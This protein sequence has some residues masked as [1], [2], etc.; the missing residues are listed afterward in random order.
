MYGGD[1]MRLWITTSV[2][3]LL[4]FFV[5]RGLDGSLDQH[6]VALSILSAFAISTGVALAQSWK[7]RRTK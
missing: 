6:D 2:V 7:R 5:I 4:A 1:Q 3:V